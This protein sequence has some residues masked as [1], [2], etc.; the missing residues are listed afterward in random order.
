[1]GD[2][3]DEA[4]AHASGVLSRVIARVYP[5]LREFVAGVVG[6]ERVTAKLDFHELL[7]LIS[8]EQVV[9]ERR[10][11]RGLLR[12]VHRCMKTRN[13]VA[14][15]KLRLEGFERA[16]E[17]MISL[18]SLIEREDLAQEFRKSV[19]VPQEKVEVIELTPVYRAKEIYYL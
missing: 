13:L 7:K 6:K 11:K 10:T 8:V 3:D 1:M 19:L 9:F 16:L 17:N 12:I 14:H 2:N 18:A 5:A 4:V 15:Q